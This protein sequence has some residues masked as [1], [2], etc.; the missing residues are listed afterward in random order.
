MKER[1]NSPYSLTHRT[2]VHCAQRE[3]ASPAKWRMMVGYGK[4]PS[5]AVVGRATGGAI[6]ISRSPWHTQ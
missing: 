4:T 5:R 1:L 2:T 3:A 6:R